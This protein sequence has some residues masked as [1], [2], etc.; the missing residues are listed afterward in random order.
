LNRL[1]EMLKE[2]DDAQ[3][4]WIDPRV[5]KVGRARKVWDG[6]GEYENQCLVMLPTKQ[7]LNQ[8]RSRPDN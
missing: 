7:V 8:L 3:G 5:A 1:E 4:F 6:G 2:S